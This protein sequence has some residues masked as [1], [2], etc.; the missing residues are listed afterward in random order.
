[1]YVASGFIEDNGTFKPDSELSFAEN[2]GCKATGLDQGRF[3]VTL[4]PHSSDVS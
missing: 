4:M 3:A 2:F 1:M